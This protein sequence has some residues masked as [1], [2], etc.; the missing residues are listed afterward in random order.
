MHVFFTILSTIPK[1][2]IMSTYNLYYQ[3][4]DSKMQQ[5]HKS[6]KFEVK[7]F[8]EDSEYFTF[9][10]YASVFGNVDLG[11][12]VVVKGAFKDSLAKNSS[13]PILWQHS[14]DE[15]IGKSLVLNE[16]DKGLYIKA[17]LPRE[18]TFVKGRVIPQMKVGSIREMSIGYFLKDYDLK[19]DVRYLKEIDVFEVSL[20]TKAMNP[21]AE[22]SNFKS[23]AASTSLPI[24]DR[25]KEWSSAD[26]V[27]RVRNF[28][29][30]TESPSADYKKYF[31]Y[32]DSENTDKFGSYKLPF[33][34]II[35]GEANII[36]RAVFNIAAVLQGARGG[37]DIPE[38]DQ[39]RIKTIVNGLYKKMADKFNDDSLVSPF[40]KSFESLKEIERS[41]KD[42]GFSNTEAKTLI[43]RVKE[44]SNQRD[45]E[46]KKIQRDAG[47]MAK[48]LAEI[49]ELT[50]YYKQ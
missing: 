12:D 22:I 11:N 32:F 46:E 4:T 9:E 8:N 27:A 15:P 35:N 24:A 31:M 39:A 45:A 40:T 34:D 43:S 41:L 16:D 21:Q 6:F 33:V 7:S 19:G 23:V 5:E 37:V 18:D 38:A 26:A 29:K 42:S 44:L 50:K 20:V 2:R 28:S 13:L 49:K 36:P 14:M 25:G 47:E 1:F 3:R 10:G 17:T 30:S 48:V